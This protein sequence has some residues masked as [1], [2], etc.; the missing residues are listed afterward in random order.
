M[1]GLQLPS[2]TSLNG[3]EELNSLSRM[4]DVVSRKHGI[5]VRNKTRKRAKVLARMEFVEWALLEG[6]IPI[7]IARFLDV[8]HS[9][10]NYYMKKLWRPNE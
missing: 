2:L 6:Y 7:E 9:T 5:D 8:D 10:I 4:A 1:S 3:L